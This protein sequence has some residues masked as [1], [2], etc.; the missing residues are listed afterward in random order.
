MDTGE[1][2]SADIAEE[3]KG[4]TTEGWTGVKEEPDKGLKVDS[5]DD[6]PVM[7]DLTSNE[8]GNQD[9]NDSDSSNSHGNYPFLPKSA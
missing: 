1:A 4:Q 3:I 6:A 7:K 9:L 8:H 5:A 2:A